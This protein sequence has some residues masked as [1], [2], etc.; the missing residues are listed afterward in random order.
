MTVHLEPMSELEFAGYFETIVRDYAKDQ[1]EAGYWDVSDALELSRKS[2]ERLLPQGV[3]TPNHYVYTVQD[4]ELR[5]GIIWM[6]ANLD[7]ANKNGFIYDIAID[8]SRR[9]KG[10]GRQAMQLIE[11][12]ARELGLGQMGLHVFAKNKVALNLYESLGY[13]TKSLNMIKDLK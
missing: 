1:V 2:T 13:E 9:G 6:K 8:E 10:Y 7:T 3:R 11:E 12:K 5:V 4:G